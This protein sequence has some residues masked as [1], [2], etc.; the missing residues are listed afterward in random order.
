MQLAKAMQC[1]EPCIIYSQLDMS[2]SNVKIE[3]LGFDMIQ[4]L[5]ETDFLPK[6]KSNSSKQTHLKQQARKEW[7]KQTLEDKHRD[8][9]VPLRSSTKEIERLTAKDH[10]K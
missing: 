8:F 9:K 5:A 6:T 3:P 10:G 1:D 4:F 2:G 7:Q